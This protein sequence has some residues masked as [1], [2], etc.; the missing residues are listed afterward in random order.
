MKYAV[1]GVGVVVAVAV[2]LSRRQ[3]RAFNRT[4][5]IQVVNPNTALP[6]IGSFDQGWWVPNNLMSQY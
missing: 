2:L 4:P 3:V 6:A 5:D 1:I